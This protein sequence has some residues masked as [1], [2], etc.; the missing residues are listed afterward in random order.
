MAT[1]K[2]DLEAAQARWAIA[3]KRKDELDRK[4]R[5]LKAMQTLYDIEYEAALQELKA[6]EEK[7]MEDK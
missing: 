5:K 6:L 4:V 1:Y 3:F 7:F 2:H